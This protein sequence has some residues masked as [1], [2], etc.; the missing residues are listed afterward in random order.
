MKQFLKQQIFWIGLLVYFVINILQAAFLELHFDEAY[1]WLYAR[2]ME[3]GYFDHPPMVA[4]FIFAGAKLF[5]GYLGVRFFFVLLSSV[6]FILL[7]NMVKPYSSFPL[8]YW[9]MVFSISLWIPYTFYA[10]PDGPLF[11][12]TILFLWLYQKYLQKRS[13]GI[14]LALAVATAG[15]IYSKYHGVLLLFFVFLSN[16]KLIKERKAWVLVF[17]TLIL[18]VPHFLWQFENQFPTFRYHLVDS[19]QTGYKIDVTI[20]Y[21]L[22]A[23]LLTGPFLGWLFLYSAFKYHWAD[24]WERALKFVFAGVFLFFFIVTFGGDIELH[25]TLIAYIPMFI[26]AYAFIVQN[27]RWLKPVKKIG[28]IGFFVFLSARIYL[29]LGASTCPLDAVRNMTGWKDEIALLQKEAGGRP[30]V[31]SESY[32]K[33]SLYAFY[34]GRPYTT[35]P[36]LSGFY[37]YSQFDLYP[38]EDNIQGKNVLF[39][40]MD[41]TLMKDNVRHIKGNIKDWYLRDISNFNSFSMLEITADT[42]T[43]LLENKVLRIPEITFYNPYPRV[44]EL[45]KNN[46]LQAH[47]QL[48]IRTKG[49]KELISQTN[50]E[51]L[52][53]KPRE[54]VSL[55]NIRFNLI[56]P[57]AGTQHI[58]LGLQNGPFLPVHSMIEFDLRVN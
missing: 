19:H 32:Q 7:W 22:G 46:E 12:F 51:N 4:A 41:S 30:V 1:Y 27:E 40:S 28:I 44:V 9:V 42:S 38:T 14:V 6:S 34:T 49:K 53:I 18:L 45:E 8:I 3:W 48:Y 15:L 10:V 13:W 23:I 52:K 39:V 11:F 50:L 17:L 35:Y 57:L 26:L 29:I 31:F 54:T 20:N 56:D 36:L 25:W 21:V 5:G 16:W 24:S 58:Y 47:L 55:K 43:F 37:K 33:A 2:N